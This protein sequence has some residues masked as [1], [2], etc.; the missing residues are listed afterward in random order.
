MERRTQE[1]R[2]MKTV[3][4]TSDEVNRRLQKIVQKKL[5]PLAKRYGVE[6]VK[7]VAEVLLGEVFQILDRGQVEKLLS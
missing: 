5:R 4:L 7:A 6:P 2:T 1:E 3:Y